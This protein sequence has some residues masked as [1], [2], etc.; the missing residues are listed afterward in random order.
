MEI[1]KYHDF[2][3]KIARKAGKILL[4]YAEK[5]LQIKYKAANKK[6]L[7]TKVDHMSEKCITE[8]IKK[9]FPDHCILS[10]ESGDCGTKKSE[11]RWVIDPVDGTTNYAHGYPFYCI[12]IALTRKNEVLAAVVY[13]PALKEIFHAAKGRGAWLNKTRLKVS[14]VKKMEIALLSTGF[15]PH[16][17]GN[18]LSLF[19]G[20]LPKVQGIRQV[21]SAALGM[22]YIA[23][24]RFDGCWT[25]INIWDVA[26][27][28]LLISEAGGKITDMHG[29]TLDIQK[30]D[31]L[32]IL[33]TNGRIHGEMVDAIKRV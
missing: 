19:A 30:K 32:N 6:D 29:K 12:S 7:V 20:I 5:D 2:A 1:E 14:K 15:N 10:E 18:D 17:K 27:G 31:Y 16:E 25:Y 22:A 26:A 28:I 9:T 13:A 33:A 23:A 3:V 21:G 11:Y 24:G 8:A 4:D